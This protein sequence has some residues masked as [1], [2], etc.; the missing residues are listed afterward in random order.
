MS[1]GS[2]SN[3]KEFARSFVTEFPQYW[4]QAKLI[5]IWSPSTNQKIASIPLT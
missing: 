2:V 1:N 3:L 4:N 5:F